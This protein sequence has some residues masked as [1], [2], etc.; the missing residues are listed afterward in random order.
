MENKPTYDIATSL[1]DGILEVVLKREVTREDI[2]NL[3]KEAIGIIKSIKPRKLLADV[4]AFNIP[5]INTEAYL[6]IRTYPLFFRSIYTVV[7][8]K[9]ENA[10]FQ[11]FQE[12]ASKVCGMRR[13]WFA[14]ID[15]AREWLKKYSHASRNDS[16]VI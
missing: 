8:D 1:N 4:R 15:K 16:L 14:D 2:P 11:S 13:K 5:H 12:L 3:Q 7:V 9:P 10:R 6:R